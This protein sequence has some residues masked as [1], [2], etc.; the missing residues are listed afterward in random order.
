M[1]LSVIS[2]TARL[3]LACLVLGAGAAAAAAQTPVAPAPE[4]TAEDAAAYLDGF[5]PYALQHGDVAGAVVVVVK[6]GQI[7]LEKGYGVSDVET[8]APVDPKTTLFRPGSTSKLFTWTAVMQLVEQGKLDL[9]Q[10]VNSYLDFKIPSTWPAPITLRHL[11]T[12]TAGF[13]E[14]IKH[15]IADDP[16]RLLTLESLVKAWVPTRIYPPGQVSAYSNYGAALAGYIV[17]RVS[18]QAFDDYVAQHVMQPLG[19]TLSTF[20]QPLPEALT[21]QMSKGYLVASGPAVP[22]ELISPAPAGSLSSTGEEMAHFMMAQLNDGAYGDARILQRDTAELMHRTTYTPVAP[23][24]GMALGFYHEDRNGHVIIGH[25]GDTDAF[26]SDL[27]LILDADV[28]IFISMNSAGKDGAAHTIRGA[29]F[30]DFLDRYFPAPPVVA[31]P[32]LPSAAQDAERLAGT[33]ESSRMSDSN[34]IRLASVIGGQP[35]LTTNSGGTISFSAFDDAAGEPKRWREVAPFQW[36]DI[37]GASRLVAIVQD[38]R[39]DKLATDDIPPVFV[40]S[41]VHAMADAG[42]NRP[43]L[44]A[45]LGVLLLT[46]L[47]WPAAAFLRWRYDRRFALQGRATTLH[48]LS[49][50]VALLDLC[51]LAGWCGIIAYGLNDLTAFDSPLDPLLRVLQVI[52]V[53]GIIGTVVPVYETFQ[54]FWDRT[55]PWWTKL[56][57]LVVALAC[58]ATVWFAFSQHLLTLGL[59]Y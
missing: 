41:P 48:R 6:D 14:T 29:L 9:D 57:S 2:A 3:V 53:V 15:L 47:A 11:M 8:Q 36:Q 45:T 46:V 28:G 25:A 54:G 37:H 20:K 55:R 40:F 18:G 27:H 16:K 50:V 12:H 5:M 58:V 30:H 49:R 38:G 34:F 32:T 31:A 59:D 17:Q 13:E 26:H 4:L 10:D 7:L 44:F 24:P 19:M 23:L 39:I 35:S 1:A 21:K 51:F 42:W 52:G 33:Y 56:A 43:L 22:F